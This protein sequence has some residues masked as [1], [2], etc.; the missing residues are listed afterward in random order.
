MK[1]SLVPALLASALALSL[2]GCAD[3]EPAPESTEAQDS[4][5]GAEEQSG[6][7]GELH[8]LP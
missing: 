5:L 4:E 2:G 7:Q 8:F 1:L 3:V 6:N